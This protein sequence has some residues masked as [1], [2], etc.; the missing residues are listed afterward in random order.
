[1]GMP[2]ITLSFVETIHFVATDFNPL[3]V[4]T[5]RAKSSIGTIYLNL[6]L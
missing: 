4:K 5:I 3:Q 6:E 1:M 2:R